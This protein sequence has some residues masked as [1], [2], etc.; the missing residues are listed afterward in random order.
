MRQAAAWPGAGRAGEQ[1]GRHACAVARTRAAVRVG[2]R[3]GAQWRHARAV[4]RATPHL[5]RRCHGP[6]RGRALVEVQALEDD[7]QEVVRDLR[8][9]CS[10]RP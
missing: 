4:A 8:G 3:R 10:G 1:A 2:G 9:S 5:R 7:L 6:C